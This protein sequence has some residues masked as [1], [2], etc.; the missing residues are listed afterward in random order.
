MTETTA[1]P[2]G[3]VASRRYLEWAEIFVRSAEQQQK[4]KSDSPFRTMRLPILCLL[5]VVLLMG[6]CVRP[7]VQYLDSVQNQATETEIRAKFGEP[8]AT[9]TL[10]DGRYV[11]HF[12]EVTSSGWQRGCM[13]W[14]LQFDKDHVLRARD[15]RTC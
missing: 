4:S 11:L 13:L 14:A 2:V 7:T 6:G 3:C 15:G 5:C 12:Q 8:Y 9:T 10:Q 1:I